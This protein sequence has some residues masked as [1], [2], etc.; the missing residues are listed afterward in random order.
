MKTDLKTITIQLREAFPNLT[1]LEI[2]QL[3]VSKFEFSTIAGKTVKELIEETRKIYWAEELNRIRAK[4]GPDGTMR[5]KDTSTYRTHD[6]FWKRL[7]AKF[8]HLDI[9]ELKKN[10]II[11]I[12]N[13]SQSSAHKTREKRNQNRIEKGLPILEN[14]GNK[15]YNACLE[16]ISALL[17]KAVDDELIPVNLVASIKRKR[18]VQKPRHGLTLEQTNQIFDVVLNGGNDPILDYLIIWTLAETACRSGGLLKIQLGDI[19]TDRNSITIYE[20]GSTTREQ[21]ITEELM[22][23]LIAFAKSRGA[24]KNEDSVFRYLPDGNGFGKQLTARRFD[25][26]WGRIGKELDWVAQKGVSC[27]WLRHTTLTW[28]DRAFNQSVAR[29]YAGHSAGNVTDGYTTSTQEEIVE[30]HAVITGKKP[31]I[32]Y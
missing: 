9:T 23:S 12:A 14:T 3:A 20:K 17:R 2:A 31:K 5:I 18:H 11:E 30:A 13:D 15:S 32:N 8:G 26:L 1:E 4:K 25:T 6:L 24:K 28:V 10:H 16:A 22:K 19:N 7:E 21:P 29:A 27:H